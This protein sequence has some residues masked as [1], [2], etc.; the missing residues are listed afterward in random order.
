MTSATL[1]PS[2]AGPQP[3]CTA[4]QR[5]PRTPR[6]NEATFEPS[7]TVATDLNAHDGERTHSRLAQNAAATKRDSEE[8]DEARKRP[9]ERQPYARLSA[10]T[11]RPMLR[12]AKAKT[13]LRDTGACRLTASISRGPDRRQIC[14]CK[15]DDWLGRRLHAVVRRHGT[16]ETNTHTCAYLDG[17]RNVST[18]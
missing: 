15:F 6:L 9:L 7:A 5:K 8:E 13:S 16:D 1:R 11:R 18:Q 3:D 14:V 4:S 12:D 2:E 10:K 17:M